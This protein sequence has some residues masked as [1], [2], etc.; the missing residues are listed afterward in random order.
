ME[1]REENSNL[2]L[3]TFDAPAN[4]TAEINMTTPSNNVILNGT[5]GNYI[6]FT[7]DIKNRNGASSGDDVI[8]V[9]TFNN[10]GNIKKET[11]IY[12]SNTTVHFLIDEYL[13]VGTNNISVVITGRNTLAGS[14]A[15]VV[16]NVVNLQLTSS[17]DFAEGVTKGVYLHVPYTLKGANVKYLE[18]YVDGVL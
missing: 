9:F 13:E 10:G 14:M 17:F 8:A 1:D 6:D 4:Y 15:A 16:F 11:R 18:W 5:T 2:L 12:N 7:F 3:V